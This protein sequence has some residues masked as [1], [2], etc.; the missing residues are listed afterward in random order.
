MTT[1]SSA[2]EF[3]VCTSCGQRWSDREDFLS[4]P[5]LDP[6]G[7]Q[8]FI[9]DGVSGLFLINHQ[10]C[11]TTMALKA[12]QFADLYDGPMY[13][14]RLDHTEECPG[15]CLKSSAT[16]VC[17]LECECAYV[18]HVLQLLR[19]WPKKPREAS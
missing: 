17:V 13:S 15:Y 14:Q 8:A 5:E 2:E 3:K 16:E 6:V 12:E 19:S 11:G 10:R 4:D 7:Y 18:G 1:R 9:E